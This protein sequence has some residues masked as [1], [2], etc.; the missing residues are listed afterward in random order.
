M[1]TNIPSK[2]VGPSPK[3]CQVI[4]L[5]KG[6]GDIEF[7]PQDH[8]LVGTSMSTKFEGPN[9]KHCRIIRL[10][11]TKGQVTLTFDKGHLLFRPILPICLVA[12]GLIIAKGLLLY[13]KQVTLAPSPTPTPTPGWGLF[14]PQ[15]HNWNIL[16]RR[17]LGNATYQIS[18]A[19]SDKTIFFPV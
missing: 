1:R 13:V 18:K 8:L 9:H 5:Y 11:D 14:S 15:V 3:H 7:C 19:L 2:F 12:L 17:P 10:F 6:P 4:K 16:I